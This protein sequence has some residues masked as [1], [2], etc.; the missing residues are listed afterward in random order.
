MENLCTITIILIVLLISI[1]SLILTCFLISYK[2]KI[3]S[4]DG[5]HCICFYFD[6]LALILHSVNIY[7]LGNSPVAYNIV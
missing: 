7:D 4:L 6:L 5:L 2:N 3:Y 1:K